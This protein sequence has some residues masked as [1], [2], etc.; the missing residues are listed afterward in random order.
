[1]NL[2]ALV[3]ALVV[4]LVAH[5]N[6]NPYGLVVDQLWNTTLSSKYTCRQVT[7]QFTTDVIKK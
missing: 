7:G 3:V 5:V 2:I 1:M 6:C 4:V